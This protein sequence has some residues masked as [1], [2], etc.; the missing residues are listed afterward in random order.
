PCGTPDDGY[1][2]TSNALPDFTVGAGTMYVGGVRVALSQPVAYGKQAEWLDHVG[3]HLWLD[4]K[5][6]D[7]TSAE[8]VYLL[9][10]EQEVSAVEDVPLREVALGGPDTAQRTRLIQRI[11]RLEVKAD[12]CAP[13]LA[14]AE[15]AWSGL[16]V[17]FD[18][19][20]MMLASPAR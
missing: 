8:F 3:D 1:K 4:P 11:V 5:T 6:I 20:T 12:Q 16:G 15:K 19:K 18:A 17:A 13:A 2:V 9:L 7:G 14:L 10:R